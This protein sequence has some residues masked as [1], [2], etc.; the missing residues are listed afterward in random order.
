MSWVDISASRSPSRSDDRWLGKLAF[1]LVW[2]GCMV[3]GACLT[4]A[5]GLQSNCIG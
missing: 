2:F 5:V 1:T 3:S 4:A